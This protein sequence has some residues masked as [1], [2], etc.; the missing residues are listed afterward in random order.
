MSLSQSVFL[1]LKFH[2][3]PSGSPS[4]RLAPESKESP[5]AYF[6]GLGRGEGCAIACVCSFGSPM[7]T[8]APSTALN[9]AF[10]IRVSPWTWSS[11]FWLGWLG[12]E[13]LGGLCLHSVE[14]GLQWYATYQTH[15]IYGC[16]ACEF[17]S[18]CLHTQHF[19]HWA[20]SPTCL[21]SC[22][23]MF[24]DSYGL[25]VVVLVNPKLINMTRKR[26]LLTEQP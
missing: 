14:Q 15:I 22:C 13:Q 23:Y 12:S 2:K 3:V 9:P 10:W 5:L 19:A 26:E 11:P 6:G 16:W 24:Y 25:T 8:S 7:S 17:R 1:W 18:L 4:L 21:P 20:I